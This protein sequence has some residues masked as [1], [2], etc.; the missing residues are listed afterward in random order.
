MCVSRACALLQFFLCVCAWLIVCGTYCNTSFPASAAAASSSSS[1][2]KK[3]KVCS[4][5][6]SA[7]AE[8]HLTWKQSQ[9][10]RNK[11]K[12]ERKRKSSRGDLL[13]TLLRGGKRGNKKKSFFWEKEGRKRIADF[14]GKKFDTKS[15]PETFCVAGAA[16]APFD[17]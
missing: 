6:K 11:D 8:Q 7:R 4:Q 5:E 16:A 14:F 3:R 1:S 15:L 12:K 2:S 17:V 13:Y 10:H 9:V